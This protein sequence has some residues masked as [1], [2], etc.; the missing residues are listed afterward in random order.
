MHIET[1]N[2]FDNMRAMLFVFAYVLFA[3][4]V[5]A[6]DE[7][8]LFV[9]GDEPKAVDTTEFTYQVDEVIPI[10]SVHGQPLGS[11]YS[12]IVTPLPLCVSFRLFS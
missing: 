1:N 3:L 4:F 9:F 12:I 7:D 6:K 2:Q 11:T 10:D 5:F 8:I